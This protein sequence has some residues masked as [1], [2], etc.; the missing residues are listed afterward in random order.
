M[1]LFGSIAVATD[2]GKCKTSPLQVG[3]CWPQPAPE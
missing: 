2:L 3:Q 1:Q